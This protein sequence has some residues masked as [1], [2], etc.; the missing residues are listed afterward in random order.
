V[1]TTPQPIETAFPRLKPTFQQGVDGAATSGGVLYV[2]RHGRYQRADG[3][4]D[5]VTL[6]ELS[7]WPQAW[8]DGRIDLVVGGLP[9]SIALVRDNQYLEIDPA[10]RTVTQ[11]PQALSG[12]LPAE[13]VQRMQSRQIDAVTVEHGGAVIAFA[14]PAAVEYASASAAQP[15]TL[16]YLGVFP[17]LGSGVQWHETW[18]PRIQQAP[19]GRVGALWAVQG[20]PADVNQPGGGPVLRHDGSDWVVMLDQQAHGVSAGAD[21]SVFAIA[22]DRQTVLRWDAATAAWQAVVQL[23]VTPG[24][25]LVQVSVGDASRVWALDFGGAAY[26]MVE[27]NGQPT[28]QRVQAA[29]LGQTGHLLVYK[30]G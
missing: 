21:G 27:V 2:F 23:P 13:V 4:D 24:N 22:P 26:R 8:S 9:D 10:T 28:L 29:G 20:I 14:G 16:A 3:T 7:G 6:S 25:P 19:T 1:S 11:A 17:A 15:S 12:L 18:Y 5:P 30:D